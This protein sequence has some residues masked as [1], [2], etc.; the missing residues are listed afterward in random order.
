MPL[1]SVLAPGIKKLD[2]QQ[3]QHQPSPSPVEWMANGT[4]LL[5]A[6]LPR[7]DCNAEVLAAGGGFPAGHR[8]PGTPPMV[9]P[10]S[11][12]HYCGTTATTDG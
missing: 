9:M 8:Y 1:G 10:L 3:Q 6:G 12:G 5:P 11:A 7:V 2:Q 4:R